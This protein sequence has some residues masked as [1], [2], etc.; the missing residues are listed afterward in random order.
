[1]LKNFLVYLLFFLLVAAIHIT[2][3]NVSGA[4]THEVEKD[5]ILAL[6]NA[7]EKA[8]QVRNED[9]RSLTKSIAKSGAEYFA[10]RSYHGLDI[11]GTDSH[12]GKFLTGRSG[13]ASGYKDEKTERSQF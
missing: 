9:T 13:K 2:I 12:P 3:A 10:S 7:T 11:N 8:L 4:D 6:V 1:M 5:E